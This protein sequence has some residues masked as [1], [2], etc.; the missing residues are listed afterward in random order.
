[1]PYETGEALAPELLEKLLAIDL[2][3]GVFLNVNFPNCPPDEVEGDARDQPGQARLRSRGS[4]SVPTAATC[5]ITGCASAASAT[6][7][8]E[9]TDLHAVRT[10]L[11]LGDAAEARPDRA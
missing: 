10:R 2:P 4:T 3:A 6:E 9:G 11:R 8:R 5:P 7:L 1:M